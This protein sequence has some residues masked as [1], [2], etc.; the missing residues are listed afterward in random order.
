MI[1][2]DGIE[3]IQDGRAIKTKVNGKSKQWDQ[4]SAVCSAWQ[5]HKVLMVGFAFRAVG[6][7]S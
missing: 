4:N 2:W 5:K 6:R 7:A 3:N 1:N